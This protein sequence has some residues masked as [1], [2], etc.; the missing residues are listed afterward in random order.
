MLFFQ[1]HTKHLG[2]GIFFFLVLEDQ[3]DTEDVSF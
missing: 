2:F 3:N 1:K